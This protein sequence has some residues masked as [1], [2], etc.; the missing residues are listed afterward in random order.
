MRKK[1][2]IIFYL[3]ILIFGGTFGCQSNLE[4]EMILGSWKAIEVLEEQLPLNLEDPGVIKLTFYNNNQYEYQ[5][6]L[7]YRE[8]GSYEIDYPYLITIDTV[9][10][11]STKKAVKISKLTTDSLF[12][13]M[14]ENEKE[15]ILKL[16]KQ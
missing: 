4:Q 11:A 3:G 8:A 13:L 5:S 6:T 9:N 2:R 12:L 16:V 15:R 10:K 1:A 14:K 7:N